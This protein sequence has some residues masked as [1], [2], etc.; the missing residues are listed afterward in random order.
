MVLTESGLQEFLL[1]AVPQTVAA[2]VGRPA[3]SADG[4]TL[5]QAELAPADAAGYTVIVHN[6][7]VEPVEYRLTVMGGVLIDN[8]GQTAF[9][10]A[11]GAAQPRSQAGEGLAVPDWIVESG[12]LNSMA[13]TAEVS[14]PERAYAVTARRFTGNLYHPVDRHYL[15]LEPDGQG[16]D[17]TLALTY[18]A[19]TDEVIPGLN[20]WL[21]TRDGLRQVMK[22]ARASEL[23]LAT[24]APAA[25]ALGDNVLRANIRLADRGPYVLVVFNESKRPAAYTVAVTGALLGDTYGQ[26]N[27]AAAA[28]AEMRAAGLAAAVI[29]DWLAGVAP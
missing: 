27:E 11:V 1:G 7:G 20:F 14:Q 17:I 12:L 5:L 6:Y 24:G 13:D 9:S 2:T 29:P 25:D 10:G 28:A 21:L 8:A 23:N 19:G 18:D 3:A 15:W 16:A 26:T 4:R 22:G